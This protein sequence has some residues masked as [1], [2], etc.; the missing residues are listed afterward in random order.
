MLYNDVC[1]F[2]KSYFFKTFYDVNI[3]KG[4]YITTYAYEIKNNFFILDKDTFEP[5]ID[6]HENIKCLFKPVVKKC[7]YCEDY[8]TKDDVKENNKF[9]YRCIK[10]LQRYA[11]NL[12]YGDFECC[13][14]GCLIH[15]DKGLGM[16]CSNCYHSNQ[17]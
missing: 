4:E 5:V 6:R 7:T 12:K 10:E 17:S 15:Q 11:D 8:L 2:D 13:I 16:Y 9:C 1:I 3:P 14:C